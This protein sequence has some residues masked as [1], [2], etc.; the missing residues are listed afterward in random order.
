MSKKVTV[1]LVIYIFFLLLVAG[2]TSAQK[3]AKIPSYPNYAAGDYVTKYLLKPPAEY[4]FLGTIHSPYDTIVGY[5]Y[6]DYQHNS[7]IPHMI[8]NNYQ[9]K[10]GGRHFTWMES[11]D[12][13][14]ATSPNRYVDYNYRSPDGSWLG[15]QRI[16]SSY[17]RGG[18]TG[19]DIMKD[20]REVLI[21]HYADW[22]GDPAPRRSM[23]AIE[24]TTPGSCLFRYFDIPDSG[25]GFGS[26]GGWPHAAIDTL[27]RI[28]VVMHDASMNFLPWWGYTRCQQIP[29]TDSILCE[30]PGIP[31]VRIKQGVF[32][33]G[34]RNMLATVTRTSTESEIVVASP[35]SGKL[36]L[37]WTWPVD[38]TYLHTSNN[39][40]YIESTNGGQD[41]I[42][43]GS[44]PAGINITNFSPTDTYK[45]YCDLAAIY[46]YDDNFHIF[47]NIHKLNTLTGEYDWDDCAIIHW[48]VGTT[49]Q[50]CGTDTIR[51][52]IVSAGKWE[53]VAGAWNRNMAKMNAGVGVPGE[54]NY[55]W[56]YSSWT[57]FNPNDLS[58]SG[59]TNG[60]IYVS[61][62][63]NSGL[64]WD[65]PRNV[66][67]SP[68]PGCLPGD[69]D[70]D[71]WPSLAARVDS[72][73]YLQ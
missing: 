32:T 54:P 38:T 17:C 26:G 8:A 36:A 5:T 37:I 16:T 20:S 23:L 34:T 9:T 46:D 48:S 49:G 47:A 51:Y 19:L 1:F 59:Y 11:P 67:N 22:G 39:V 28:H 24:S 64:T 18:Y 50:I 30:S 45:A 6:Y 4:S 27:N 68:D 2:K 56:I 58:A 13:D 31:P 65:A 40:Y 44:F 53:A 21:F 70:S 15:P 71:H 72:F 10:G 73:L 66:T 25:A 52:N 3:D 69:C 7:S 63:T 60:E 55:N 41:W 62:S 35:I 43:A 33:S 42:D 29:G 57:Q 61:V 14:I 12:P